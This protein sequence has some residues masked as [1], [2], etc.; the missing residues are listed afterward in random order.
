[1]N[2]K[3]QGPWSLFSFAVFLLVSPQ[4]EAMSKKPIEVVKEVIDMSK[5]KCSFFGHTSTVGSV[6][7]PADDNTVCDPLTSNTAPSYDNG[8]LGKLILKTPQMSS[9]PKSVLDF[10]TKGQRLEQNLYFADVNVPTQKFSKGFTTRTGE[11]LEDTAGAKLIENFAI[12][13]TSSLKLAATDAPGHYEIALLSDDGARLFV[14]E[15][16]VWNEI[17]NNDGVHETRMGCPFRT[18]YLDRNTE[19]PIKILYYQGPR[20]YIANV[21]MW[22]RHNSAQTWKEPARHSLCGFQGNGLFFSEQN[23]NRD[24]LVMKLL[25][26]DG[27]DVVAPANYKMPAASPNPCA[28]EKLTVSEIS[29]VRSGSS[30]V[31]SWKTNLP[32]TSQVRIT[33]V[34]TGEV[35]MSQLDSKMVN[36]HTVQIDGLNRSEKYMVEVISVD[37]SGYQVVGVPPVDI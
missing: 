11:V 20:F 26:A 7:F 9:N 25:K 22:K 35:M 28:E 32:A 15:N 34:S 29:R 10:H 8:L 14:Q 18:V 5:I 24:T 19:I 33:S 16:N 17:V 4:S 21:M 23:P 12:E 2:V 6:D 3:S 31:V 36:E 37:A 13:Y 30:A 1:M 27:W